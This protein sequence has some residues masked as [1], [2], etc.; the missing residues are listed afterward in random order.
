MARMLPDEADAMPVER[1]GVTGRNN[2]RQEFFSCE[3]GAGFLVGQ[4][5]FPA[6]EENLFCDEMNE[7]RIRTGGWR[8][9]CVFPCFTGQSYEMALIL[10]A[11]LP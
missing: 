3:A 2:C 1:G 7:V 11:F 8:Q 9:D 5:W 6:G 4:G 10:L